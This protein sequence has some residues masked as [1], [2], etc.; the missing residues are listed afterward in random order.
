MDIQVRDFNCGLRGFVTDEINKLDF[1]SSR[2]G[3]CN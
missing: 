3:I 2:N 1:E